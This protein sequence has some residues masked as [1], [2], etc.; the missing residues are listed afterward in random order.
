MDNQSVRHS[1]V[2]RSCNHFCLNCTEV[3]GYVG[4]RS[5]SHTI[6]CSVIDTVAH[7]SMWW[8]SKIMLPCGR[9]AHCKQLP[10]SLCSSL[11]VF[12][13]FI[14][15]LF[16][17]IYF[18]VSFCVCALLVWAQD[19][20]QCVHAF[21]MWYRLHEFTYITTQCSPHR[22]IVCARELFDGMHSEQLNLQGGK[23]VL[24]RSTKV[25]HK[26]TNIEMAEYQSSFQLCRLRCDF[27]QKKNVYYIHGGG[28]KQ[29]WQWRY[30]DGCV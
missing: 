9:C 26:Q 21:Q 10:L 2:A 28:N 17:Y 24:Q 4:E 20:V 8:I 6:A 13:V 18:V 5:L 3:R 15:W 27:F 16:V 23:D 25:K 29:R 30:L 7:A 19:Q 1:G 12:S 11:V 14:R 22:C